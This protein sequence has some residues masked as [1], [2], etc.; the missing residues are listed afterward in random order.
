M[1]N[2]LGEEIRRLRKDR[3]FMDLVEFAEKVNLTQG[4][5][6]NIE[7]GVKIPSIEKLI[8]IADAL[9]VSKLYLFKEAG[10]LDET[11]ILELADENRRFREALETIESKTMSHYLSVDNMA[12]D[13]QWIAYKALK[14][15]KN[16]EFK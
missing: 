11:D 1:S 4:Y 16:N 12:K 14:G 10:Y 13:L 3:A 8:Q 2:R 5:L 7:L 15:G 9:G 6:S